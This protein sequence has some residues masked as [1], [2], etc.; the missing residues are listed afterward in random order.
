M[1][2]RGIEPIL[3]PV[4]VRI[5]QTSSRH[6]I[7]SSCTG[8]MSL[9]SCALI[10]APPGA[11][12]AMLEQAIYLKMVEIAEQYP[13]PYRRRYLDAAAKFGLPYCK[14]PINFA[15]EGIHRSDI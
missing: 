6:G 10:K 11:Y 9:V 14:P 8:Q 3:L 7:V 2:G 1:A 15:L 5:A 12:L 4:I 13:E